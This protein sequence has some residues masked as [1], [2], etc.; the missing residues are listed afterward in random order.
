MEFQ[1]I[2][3]PLPGNQ[4]RLY[5]PGVQK[6]PEDRI[7][8]WW[9]VTPAAIALAEYLA[10]TGDLTG[11]RVIELG[12]GL[13]LAGIT[14][15]MLGATVLFTDYMPEALELAEK[16][17]RLNTIPENM[18]DFMIVD[19][20]HT[21]E[22]P[23]FDIILGSEILYDYFFHSSL[24][25]MLKHILHPE[26]IIL[27]TDRKRLV[28]SR[29]IGQLAHAGFVSS[30]SHKFPRYQGFPKQEISIFHLTRYND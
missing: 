17:A 20:E 2:H 15:A 21:P 14:A 26:G 3:I 29:F 27:L 8:F 23:R 10:E 24:I 5:H 16:N 13:G 30:E 1:E 11:K 7:S 25:K 9:N 18:T 12:C 19:W 4:V 6:E 22:M 28:V